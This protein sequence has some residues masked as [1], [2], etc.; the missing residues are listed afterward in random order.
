M[1]DESQKAWRRRITQAEWD[2]IFNPSKPLRTKGLPRDGHHGTPK[3]ST[4][5][6]RVPNERTVPLPDAL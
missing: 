2:S 6:G 4:P 5:S 1:I 3:A